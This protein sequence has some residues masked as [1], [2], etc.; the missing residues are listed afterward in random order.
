M[1][2]AALGQPAAPS[3]GRDIAGGATLCETSTTHAALPQ[4]LVF[5]TIQPVMFVLLFRY[6]F[7][8][9]IPVLPGIDY[10]NFL[11]PGICVQAVVFGAMNTAIGLPPTSSAA[12]VE[13]L[14]SLPMARSAVLAGRI[15][16]DLVRNVFVVAVM[17][18]VGLRRRLPRA[19]RERSGRGRRFWCCSR[20]GSRSRGC[21]PSSGSS[22]RQRRE[23]PDG[24]LPLVMPLV[25]RERSSSRRTDARL[26]AGVRSTSR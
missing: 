2:T 6:V 24:G 5:T 13:R 18:R 25:S 26:A 21:S 10:V 14:R 23:G 8:G 20:S 16:A 1:T 17:T 11:M 15:L 9:A 12:C 3:A 7:G 4:L 22:V 19:E